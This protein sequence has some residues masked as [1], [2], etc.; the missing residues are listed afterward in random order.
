[1]WYFEKLKK[2]V[3]TCGYYQQ[4]SD[5]I[6]DGMEGA[7]SLDENYIT[8]S[9]YGIQQQGIPQYKFHFMITNNKTYQQKIKAKLKYRKEIV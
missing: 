2:I 3:H 6:R 5:R 4:A 9:R 8:R 7:N 1:L